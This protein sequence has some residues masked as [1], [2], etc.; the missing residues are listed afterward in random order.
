MNRRLLVGRILAAAG[1]RRLVLYGRTLA[2]TPASQPAG[3]P[4]A[5]GFVGS[6]EVDDLVRLRPELAAELATPEAQDS[7]CFVARHEAR[8]VSM[9]WI[10]TTRAHSDFLGLSF[11]LAESTAF[12][13]GTWTDPSV[14]GLGVAAAT[15]AALHDTLRD[16]GF[17]RVLRA[18]WPE[19]AAGIRNVRRE[20]FSEIERWSGLRL[21]PIRLPLHQPRGGVSA[22]V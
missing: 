15:G 6:E 9:R 21:G 16:E 10:S 12:N 14:R 7:R 20:G 22:R 1:Y 19:N 5:F 11:P 18:V 3:I 2:D 13:W 8:I 17:E 4:L